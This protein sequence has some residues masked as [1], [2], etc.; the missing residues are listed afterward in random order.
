MTLSLLV[1][2]A[3]AYSQAV[4]YE[5]ARALYRSDR[6]ELLAQLETLDGNRVREIE[7]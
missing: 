1:L 4:A 2:A 7:R 6:D 3:H 5:E